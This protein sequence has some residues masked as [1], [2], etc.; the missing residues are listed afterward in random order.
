[1]AQER[2]DAAIRCAPVAGK[3]LV[4]DCVA[5]LRGR[6]SAQPLTGAAIVIGADMP[7]MPMAH[8]VKPVEAE[9]AGKPGEYR[10]RI[11]L[12]MHGEWALKLHLSKPRRDL[13]IQKMMFAP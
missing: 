12:D 3:A 11:A 5:T 6:A 2:I 7:A 4:Y 1:M 13:I 8:N 10:F 9:A